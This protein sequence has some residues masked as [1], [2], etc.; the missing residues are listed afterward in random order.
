MSQ[1]KTYR[2]LVIT[3]AAMVGGYILLNRSRKVLPSLIYYKKYDMSTN[4]KL[5]RGY[6]NNN[7]LNVRYSTWNNWLGKV[8]PNM[9]G[10]YEQFIDM[11][12]GYRAAL[13]LIRKY[14]RQGYNTISKIITRWAP[15]SDGNYTQNYIAH[16]AELVGI[17]ADKVISRDDKETLCAMVRAM[18]ISENGH[19]DSD[20]NNLQ[21]TYGLPS[22]D[23]IEK[24]WEL[25]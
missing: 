18:S 11:A 14:I 24:G 8:T 20:G 9:D 7:P 23:A 16:V 6:R 12:H 17:P 22:I 19:K 4:P 15:E 25:I 21:S 5:P 3:F 1:D 10:A 2:T 13:Y